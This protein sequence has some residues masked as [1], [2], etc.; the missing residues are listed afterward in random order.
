MDARRFRPKHGTVIA[1]LAL[2]V[3]LGGTSYAAVAI[4]NNSIKSK[5]IAKG[6][7]K[8]AD[9]GNNAVNAAKVANGSLL[10]TDFKA[11]QLPAG[12]TGATGATGAKGDPGDAGTAVGYATITS[13]GVVVTSKSKNVTQANVDADT[14]AG[15]YCFTGLPFTVRGAMVSNQPV[16]DGGEQDVI[17]GVFH[18]T[19]NVS[20]GDCS[21]EVLVRTFDVSSAVLV[22]RAFHIWFED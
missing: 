21:G 10:A 8:R 14:V 20:S 11:G 19:T 1:Y 16:F 9:I 15:T 12:A 5:H 3:A 13:G 4:S 22:D 7:V 18:T 2:F 6:A 17:V